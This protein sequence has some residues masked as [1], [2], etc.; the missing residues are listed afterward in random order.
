MVEY[1]TEAKFNSGV[2]TALEI[3]RLFNMANYFYMN[4]NLDFYRDAIIV[5]YRELSAEMNEKDNDKH[6][7]IFIKIDKILIN[8]N[9]DFQDA[10]IENSLWRDLHFWELELRMIAKKKG[11]LVP[12]KEDK[13]F[14][15][16]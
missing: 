5:V 3:R 12:D 6:K 1:N 7:E 14:I 13:R 4:G 10:E 9:N 11:L 16:K 8:D 15:I 2:S